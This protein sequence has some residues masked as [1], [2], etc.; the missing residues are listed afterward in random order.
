MNN[1]IV[2]EL[3][4]TFQRRGF[5]TLRFNFRG[6]RSGSETAFEAAFGAR[7]NDF[8]HQ[9]SPIWIALVERRV[10]PRSSES[11]RHD[12]GKDGTGFVPSLE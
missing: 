2:Q 6:A 11:S 1:R 8:R 7:K 5:A 3:Y 10:P 4:K 9:N 12:R